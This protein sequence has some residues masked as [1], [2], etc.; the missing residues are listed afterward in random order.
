[1]KDKVEL[2]KDPE[3][4]HFH[5]ESLEL[6][7]YLLRKA[8]ECALIRRKVPNFREGRAK[9]TWAPETLTLLNEEWVSGKLHRNKDGSA[10]NLVPLN[11]CWERYSDT[12][13]TWEPDTLANVKV[14]VQRMI[15]EF[16]VANLLAKS[17]DGC[18][19]FCNPDSMPDSWSWDVCFGLMFERHARMVQRCNKA[20]I[21]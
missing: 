12:R 7:Q 5:R 4:P 15:E 1:M 18:Y 13:I 21:Y 9:M 11:V 17:S 2:S 20:R 10:Q 14:L 8:K 6:D 3:N 16:M 19:W